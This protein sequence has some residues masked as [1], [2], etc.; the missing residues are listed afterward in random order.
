L[1]PPC[2]AATGAAQRKDFQ[3]RALQR[4]ALRGAPLRGQNRR[5]SVA[6]ADRSG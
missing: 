6:F 2:T 5:R 3:F 1:P 4:P